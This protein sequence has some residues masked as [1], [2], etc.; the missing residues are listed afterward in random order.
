MINRKSEPG[1]Y[2]RAIRDTPSPDISL[3][4]ANGCYWPEL[5][6]MMLEELDVAEKAA[7]ARQRSFKL[8]DKEAV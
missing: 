4:P 8:Q 6:D 3:C 1:N 5:Q 2:A 7:A